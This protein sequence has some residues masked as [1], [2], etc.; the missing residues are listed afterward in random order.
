MSNRRLPPWLQGLLALCGLALVGLAIFAQA[1]GIDHNAQ[2]GRGR[3][4]IFLAGCLVLLGL[5]ARRNAARIHA[6]RAR[7]STG[8]DGRWRAFLAT[9]PLRAAGAV[10]S[11]VA[12]SAPARR[13]ARWSSSVR[14]SAPARYL[15]ARPE[16]PAA[17]ATLGIVL[18][19]ELLYVWQVS[20][21]RM[22]VW[23]QSSD[24]FGLLGNAF[25]HGQIAL[26]ERPAPELLALPNPYEP[27]ER[28]GFKDFIWDASLYNGNYYLY[29]GPVPGLVMAGVSSLTPLEIGDQGLVFAF[30]SAALVF[31]ALLLL[32]LRRRFFPRLPWGLTALTV[33]AAGL[34]NPLPWLLSRPS[35]YEAAIAGGQCFLMAGLYWAFTGLAE[36]RPS[37]WRL[38]LAGA[39]LALTVGSRTTL[40]FTVVFLGLAVLWRLLR[41][42]QG[43]KSLAAALAF[44]LPLLAGAAALAWYNAAR[45][46]SIFEF[47]HRY[48]L[49]DINLITLYARGQVLSLS[50]LVPNLYSYLIRPLTFK[51]VFPFA[52]APRID[53]SMWPAFVSLPQTYYSP[54]PV[55]GLAFGVPLLWLASLPVGRLLLRLKRRPAAP[56]A[57]E[58]L[59]SW[60]T[61]CLLGALLLELAPTLLFYYSSMRYLADV[62]PTGVILSA[63]GLWGAWEATR[64]KWPLRAALL[65]VLLAT[66]AI[67]LALGFSGYD[68]RFQTLNPA[69]YAW[70]LKHF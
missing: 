47:G 20:A 2:W 50:Y 69:L 36:A 28:N 45:F 66:P 11:R 37:A 63:L 12:G 23:P 40:A 1:L 25:K 55:T 58:R 51:A 46:G 26:V 10:L 61:V 4:L 38:F 54:E 42:G 21:G 39:C 9:P 56:S 44:G 41:A 27:R 3:W 7:F 60:W 22:S 16:R 32:A 43:W 5:L 62:A 17:L 64:G 29:W 33:L 70:L 59:F 48:Q 6:A 65:L 52:F 15:S 14:A 34:A 8:L 30:L 57:E 67:G 13:L 35:V 49:T 53:P 18:L 19:V 24:Y 31:S 68:H